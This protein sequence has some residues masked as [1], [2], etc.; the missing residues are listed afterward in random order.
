MRPVR[1]FDF[2]ASPARYEHA[3]WAL[4]KYWSICVM[5]LDINW[6]FSQQALRLHV[7][8]GCRSKKQ[9]L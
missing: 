3:T 6:P 5:T 2:L 4:D 9:C 8:R 7:F 1:T